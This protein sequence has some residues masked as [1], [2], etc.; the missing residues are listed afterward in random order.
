MHVC[1][2]NLGIEPSVG[3]GFTGLLPVS[4]RQQAAG[5]GQMLSFQI[6]IQLVTAWKHG[7]ESLLLWGLLA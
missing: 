7:L 3:C 2:I 5:N 6:D 4:S 1:A